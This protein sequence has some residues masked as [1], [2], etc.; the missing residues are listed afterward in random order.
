MIEESRFWWLPP[1]LSPWVTFSSARSSAARFA[2]RF[3]KIYRNSWLALRKSAVLTGASMAGWRIVVV[4]RWAAALVAILGALAGSEGAWAATLDADAAGAVWVADARGL[5]K[6]DAARAD[7]VLEVAGVPGTRALAVDRGA[8]VLWA[9]GGGELRAF[10]LGGRALFEV[11]VVLAGGGGAA[12]GTGSARPVA[13]AGGGAVWVADGTRLLAF[14]ATGQALRSFSLGS[15][16]RGLALDVE[17]GLLWVATAARVVAY[18]SGD[19]YERL[20]LALGER[21]QVVGIACDAVAG[22]VWVAHVDRLQRHGADGTRQLE[23]AGDAAQPLRAVAEDGAT[24]VWIA[25]GRWLAHVDAVGRVGAPVGPFAARGT[26]GEMAV[27]PRSGDVWVAGEAEL[28][29]VSAAGAVV[30]QLTFEPPLSILDL[31]LDPG[32]TAGGGGDGERGLAGMIVPGA[33]AAPGAPAGGQGALAR[34]GRG[35]AAKRAGD[36]ARRQEAPRDAPGLNATVV[37]GT[38]YLPDGAVLAGATVNVLGQPAV[39]ATTAA[40]GTFSLSNVA[41]A[42]GLTLTVTVVAA[43]PTGQTVYAFQGVEAVPGG[44]SDAGE[45]FLSFACS[46]DFSN[47]LFTANS[48]GGGNVNA[49]ASFGG[50]LVAAGTFTSALIGGVNTSGV[51]RI[52]V[53]NGS[54]WAKLGTGLSGGTS[55]AVDALAVFGGQLYVGGVFTSAGG[56]T[57]ANVARWNGTS[58]SAVGSGLPGTV[59]ALGVWNGTLYAGGSFTTSGSLHFNHVAA[60]NGTS[61]VAV[62]GGFGSDVLAL[63]SFDDGGGSGP[64]LYAGGSFAS[65][66]LDGMARWNATGSPA[67]WVAVGGGVTGTSTPLVDAFASATMG[68]VPTLYAGGS[69]TAA[70]GVTAAGVAQWQGGA[71]SAVSTNEQTGGAG[72]A[73]RVYA[74][75]ILDDGYGPFLYAAGTFGSP[76]NRLAYWQAGSDNAWA[77]LIGATGTAGADNTVEALAAWAPAGS[78]APPLEMYAGGT[79]A[80]AGGYTSTRLARWGVGLSCADTVSP[81]LAVAA[82]AY[83]AATN[84]SRPSIQVAYLDVG[85]GLNTST[86]KILANGQAL[87]ASCTFASGVATCVP[88]SAL[89]DGLYTLSASAADL[90]GNEA[91]DSTTGLF[92]L[93]SVPP[94]VSVTVPAEGASVPSSQAIRVAWSDASAGVNPQS[95]VLRLN[96]GALAA[97]CAADAAGAVCTPVQPL[98]LGAA[99]LTVSIADLAGNAATSAARHFTVANTATTVTGTVVLADGTAAGGAQVTILGASAAGATVAPTAMTAGDGTFSVSGVAAEAGQTLTVTA[100]KTVGSSLLIGVAANLPPVLGGT[101]AAGTITLLPSCAPRFVDGLFP[102]TGVSGDPSVALYL[103]GGVDPHRNVQ[104]LLGFGQGAGAGGGGQALYAWGD[105][106]YAGGRVI[107]TVAWWDGAGWH[108][109]GQLAGAF[110]LAAADLGSGPALY[111]L[112]GQTLTNQGLAMHGLAQWTGQEWVSVGGGTNGTVTALTEFDDGSGPALFIAGSFQE[113]AYERFWN[114]QSQAM[115]APGTAKWNG[116]AWTAVPA[117]A[118][119]SVDQFAVYGGTLYGLVTFGTD[120]ASDLYKWTGSTWTLVRSFPEGVTALGTIASGSAGGLAGL[121]VADPP[122]V[123][124][125]DG[126]SWTTISPAGGQANGAALFGFDDGSGGGSKLYLAGSFCAASCATPPAGV[127]VWAG[128]TSWTAAGSNPDTAKEGPTVLA[129][130]NDGTATR[131][132]AGGQFLRTAQGLQANGVEELVGG[133]LVPLGSQTVQGVAPLVRSLLVW[134]DGTGPALYV[135]GSFSN[136][137]G[138]GGVAANGIARWDGKRWSALRGGLGTG[139]ATD[140]VAALEV[141]NGAL[142]AGGFFAV[143]DGQPAANVA[144]WDGFHWSAVGSGMD[145][146]V[147]A[148]RA[149]NGR[150]Y[151]GGAFTNGGLTPHVAQWDGSAWS[152]LQAGVDGMRSSAGLG[153]SV[154]ALAVY[155]GALYAAGNFAA[156]SGVAANGIARWDGASWSGIGGPSPAVDEIEALAVYDDGAGAQLFLGGYWLDPAGSSTAAYLASWDGANLNVL[157]APTDYGINALAAFDDG[158]GGGPALYLGGSFLG[159]PGFAPANRFAR[160]RQGALTALS[161]GAYGSVVAAPPGTEGSAES[162][163]VLALAVYDDRS[164]TGPALFAGGDFT[165]AGGT[166][167]SALAKWVAPIGCPD[168]IPPRIT[169]SSPADGAVTNQASQTV[170]GTVNKAVTLT[171]DGAP[172]T[173]GGNLAWSAPATLVEGANALLLAASDG[174]GG[175]AQAALTVTLDTI[176]PRLSWSAPL[177][178]ATVGSATPPLRLAYQDGGSGVVPATLAVRSGGA[179]L[180]VTCTFGAAGAL[181]VPNQPLAAGSVTLTATIADGAGNTSAPAVVTFTV[182]PVGGGGQT[183]VTGAVTLAAGTPVGGAQVSVLG[184]PGAGVAPVASAADGSFAIAG[185]DVSAGVPVGV[186]AHAQVSGVALSGA[187]TGVAPQPGGTTDVGAVR[188]GAPCA[189]AVG[190]PVLSEVG[191]DG[192]GRRVLALAV[193]DDGQGGGP[194]LYAGGDFAQA[195]GVP[196][197]NLAR[198]NGH[199][200]TAVGGGVNGAVRALAVYDDGGGGGPALYAGGDFMTAGGALVVHGVARWNGAAWSALG[201]GGGASGVAGSVY[202]LAVYDD[203]LGGGPALYAG[204]AFSAAGGAAAAN[205][206][207]WRGV[208]WSAVGAGAGGADGTVYALA[209]FSG[210]LIAGGA[211]GHAGGQAAASLAQ[212]NGSAWSA[213]AYGTDSKVYAL[214]VW[215]GALY[216]G[217]DFTNA[218]LAQQPVYA[219]AR[220]DGGSGWS[221]LAGGLSDEVL[222][223][224]AAPQEVQALAVYDDG[225]GAKLYATGQFLRGGAA[226][227]YQGAARWDGAAWTAVGSGFDAQGYGG[228]ALAVYDDGSGAGAMLY[229]GGGFTTAGG[230]GAHQVARWNGKTWSALGSGGTGAD[231]GVA[232]LAVFDDGA[233]AGPALYAGGDFTTVAG[234]AASHA[235]R[236]DAALWSQLGAG[237]DA[238]VSSLAALAGPAAALYAGGDFAHA[239]GLPAGY[240]AAWPA[241]GAGGSGGGG[242][243]GGGASGPAWSPLGAGAGAPVRVVASLDAFGTGVAALYAGGDFASPG[244]HVASWNGSAWSALG[245]GVDGTVRALASYR[246]SGQA[247]ALYVGGDFQNAGGS[248]AAGVARWDGTSWSAAGGGV[249]GLAG[250]YA[251]AVFDDAGG[252]GPALYAGG[253]SSGGGGSSGGGALFRWSGGAWTAVGGSFDGLVAVLAVFDDGSGGGPALYAGGAFTSAG[254]AAAPGL[255]RWSGTSWSPVVTGGAGERRSGAAA[256]RFGERRGAHRVGRRRRSGAVDRRRLLPRQPRR[257]RRDAC[258]PGEVVAGAHLRRRH[259]A[260]ARLHRARRGCHARQRDARARPRLQLGWRRRRSRHPGDDRQRGGGGHDLRH[261]IRRRRHPRLHARGAAAGGR[262]PSLGHDRQS[263]RRRLGA[264]GPGR[265][266]AGSHP[267]L[268]RACR[269]RHAHQRDARARP[270]LHPIR[271]RRRHRLGGDDRQRCGGGHE[272]RRGVRR[273]RHPRLHTGGAAAGG[274]GPS[275]GDDRRRGRRRLGAGGRRRR[276]AGPDPALHRARRGLVGCQLDARAGPRLQRAAGQWLLRCRYRLL[277]ADERRRRARRHLHLRRRRRRDGAVHAG[278]TAP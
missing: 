165:G 233:G 219:I 169:V 129:A 37:T 22:S 14:D 135:G 45:I 99:T 202:A 117:A 43:A 275:L 133:A 114:G 191:I 234:L 20:E 21:P 116:T 41:A 237:T 274:R 232:A 60:W 218:G 79:F 58:W 247:A 227:L 102:G 176:A 166:N 161:S 110:G 209:S 49:L 72:L 106:G 48:L 92:I 177:A 119:G 31:A 174:F 7:L 264:G 171:L 71:W 156:V 252:G 115:A 96:G 207:R 255:A 32:A 277:G 173:V 66:G 245:G 122:G 93:D 6:L 157:P 136:V 178:G 139:K 111:A 151:A 246:P 228:A 46:E 182:A 94:Q 126:A 150:L 267:E 24:G 80:H 132:V 170:A 18:G 12:A 198:W 33:E 243:G 42:A 168:V 55:P 257:G 28:A 238:R 158:T 185:V 64:Q 216:M 81:V 187:V 103:P 164:G 204:G 213:V 4:A 118:T 112:G 160:Y 199:G 89:A 137:G 5:L 88:A 144:R 2:Q 235:V 86:L 142:Y 27:D 67:A 212:W 248:P 180:A 13:V 249:A 172:V 125:W 53:W 259:G 220:W 162:T 244:A 215:N 97:T 19:G 143:A 223:G 211:F 208:A 11:P 203:G 16:V 241:A 217:G 104:G 44:V 95:A 148:L 141:Y 34:T 268:H 30:R 240:L 197:A 269:G 256:P 272:L 128:G 39:S 271:R 63:T 201:G 1:L 57:V 82:P 83:G 78:P 113:V 15:A 26:I 101:T 120:D 262:G 186:A 192:G 205:V 40:D 140:F 159:L 194:A 167:S 123:E 273:R 236:W 146:I 59:E 163:G 75:G 3:R 17:R 76:Y 25:G 130:W 69:F 147:H 214:Q 225:T 261:G 100:E 51:N 224:V 152:G 10:D 29:R 9:Y 145:G 190:V 105:F 189:G 98:P 229:A 250:V 134:D 50:G 188:L 239:G 251:L 8:G 131:L 108:E 231:A 109:L 90:A 226:N 127:F 61:W 193:F 278:G 77:P 155:D 183:T 154:A 62:G 68:G 253:A 179:A 91:D 121:Y 84:S 36:A 206:A 52:A 38:V 56:V 54:T 47:G 263:E 210:R 230:L 73:S 266:G 149:W 153:I 175:T 138:V 270:R 254:G 23:V 222:A 221:G 181:C 265:R 184:V 196:A 65:G 74:L 276:G 124:R 35:G 107:S 200:W 85:G 70:G 258:V 260:G 87:A 195:G 242:G